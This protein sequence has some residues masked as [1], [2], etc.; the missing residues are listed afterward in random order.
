LPTEFALKVADKLRFFLRGLRHGSP[1]TASSTGFAG[2]S[3]DP[4]A[5]HFTST[6][7]DQ[8][9]SR[10]K[11]RL[12]VANDAMKF[13]APNPP[14]IADAVIF[15]SSRRRSSAKTTAQFS[16]S[17]LGCSFYGSC[18]DMKPSN[19]CKIGRPAGFFDQCSADHAKWLRKLLCLAI[20][21]L[22]PEI[23]TGSQKA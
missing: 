20:E 6:S 15:T 7:T 22:S 12:P 9:C 13:V 23:A 21:L 18:L 8:S 14:G 1:N 19:G 2:G 3:S 16:T 5:H 10:V 11:R 17:G 4:D